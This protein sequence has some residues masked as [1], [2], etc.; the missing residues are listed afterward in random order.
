MP[1]RKSC[2]SARAN[3]RYW[4]SESLTPEARLEE[5]LRL[6]PVSATISS[7]T[8]PAKPSFGT[9]PPS[10]SSSSCLACHRS[11]ARRCS[12]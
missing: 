4:T 8:W 11:S 9:K 2:F 6:S 7:P 1:V 3:A 12:W 5:T 10:V